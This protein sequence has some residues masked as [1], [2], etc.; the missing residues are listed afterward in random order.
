[1]VESTTAP[2]TYE[3]KITLPSQPGDYQIDVSLK[4]NLGKSTEKK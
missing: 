1:L 2:G 4:N 3:G